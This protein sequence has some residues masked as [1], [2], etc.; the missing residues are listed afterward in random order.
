MMMGGLPVPP[1]QA[2]TSP[3][4]GAGLPAKLVS[5][6]QIL[7]A[8][9]LADPRGCAYREIEVMT[10]SIW[11]G[12]GAPFK[13]HGWVLPPR[14]GAPAAAVTWNG[15][16][17]PVITAGGAA[18]LR[19]DVAALAAKEQAAHDKS[20]AERPGSGF[21]RFQTTA[22]Q[23]NLSHETATAV[24]VALLLRL[25]E[26]ALAKQLWGALLLDE[27]LG[28]LDDPYLLVA[29]DWA[30]NLFER[31]VTAHMRGDTPVAL[32]SAKL[33]AAA[34][35]KIEAEADRRKLERREGRDGAAAPHV[36]FIEQLP[37]LV[38]DEERRAARG[39]RQ[40]LPGAAE[41]AAL[42]PDARVKLL[43]E[44]LDDVAARQWGQPGG[45]D[46][47][48]DPIVTALIETGAP[49]VEPL[50]EVLETDARLTRSVHFWRDFAR[51]R[52]LLGVHEAAYVALAGILERPFFD[53]ASTGDNLSARGTD[54]RRLV[55]DKVRAYWD[56]WKRIPLEERWY[57]VLDDDRAKPE[58]WL[59]AADK[60][61]R[62]RNVMVRP[63]ST[64]F[65]T[66]VTSP[67]GQPGLRGDPL[68]AHK[69]PSVTELL[70]KRLRDARLDV[71][72]ACSLARMLGRWDIAAGKPQL[73]KQLARAAADSKGTLAQ[74]HCIAGLT[75]DLVAAGE[76]SAL[77]A[78]AAWLGA[79][80]PPDDYLDYLVFQ[81]MWQ[82]PTRPSIVKA[83]EA[84][85]RD[86]S[87]WVPLVATVRGSGRDRT[88]LLRNELI[89]VAGFGAH[90]GKALADSRTV[91]T[92]TMR[93]GG[94]FGI[95]MVSGGSMSTSTTDPAP[96]PPGT[97]Q[98]VRVS[99]SYAWNLASHHDAAPRFQPFWPLAQRDAALAQMRTWV[100]AQRAK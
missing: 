97:T 92:L 2:D 83:A 63:S 49:A 1:R 65:T 62:P 98:T 69:T 28:E 34:A 76:L 86:G 81:P 59:D 12:D 18:E 87:P 52:S 9:G 84:L 37:L 21:H 56:Q 47:A 99:D 48:S 39:A 5:A 22:E 73:A 61:T 23:Y 6:A 8:Q 95:E 45:V 53:P 11:G 30:W 10:G 75:A 36:S 16:V 32:A 82:H 71:R 29:E 17:Y 67:N 78:Y 43:I 26:P 60:I 85:F 41:L 33:L 79:V 77:D 3:I 90:V 57:K 55:A 50:I 31:A 64:V 46:L 88:D 70:E 25:G 89:R 20:A 54:G 40:K 24:K 15:L 72:A 68:R 14:D 80:V 27:S 66:T 4:A 94:G 13:T 35:P 19:A 42:D 51:H 38:A 58:E 96:P 74:G 93:E 44:H 91:G 100:A 7:F